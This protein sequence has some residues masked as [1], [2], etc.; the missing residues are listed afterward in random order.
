M[1]KEYELKI[2]NAVKEIMRGNMTLDEVEICKSMPIML[3]KYGVKN[4]PIL[5][6]YD[7]IG[8]L[9]LSLEEASRLN[10]TVNNKYY[11]LGK[12]GLL[13]IIRYLFMPYVI[14]EDRE[15]LI[16]IAGFKDNLMGDAVIPFKL[17]L[18]NNKYR[19]N[20]IEINGDPVKKLITRG[21]ILYR[22]E[23]V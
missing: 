11:G 2:N 21:K 12:N 23:R 5:I 4:L 18:V 15:D 10:Y 13:K 3:R 8:S 14:I 17:K 16:V 9:V 7:V 1:R 20:I 22:S 19:I 6:D